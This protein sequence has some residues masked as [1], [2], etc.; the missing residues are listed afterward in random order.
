MSRIALAILL[1]A[2]AARGQGRVDVRID[3]P[4]AG[5]SSL[6]S[7]RI[8]GRAFASSDE[9]RPHLVIVIDVSGSAD[10]KS[11]AGGQT[12]LEAEI[13][14]AKAL[15]SRLEANEGTS[16]TDALE[17]SVIAFAANP[18]LVEGDARAAL[19]ALPA[20]GGGTSFG[21]ALAKAREVLDP[22]RRPGRAVVV[23]LTDGRPEDGGGLREAARLRRE[24]AR[25]HAF[26][27]GA[28]VDMETMRKIGDAVA[29]ERPADIVRRMPRLDVVLEARVARVRVRNATTGAGAE[30]R[31]RRDG[32]F[33]GVVPVD[34][35][36]GRGNRIVV[37]AVGRDGGKG[38]PRSRSRGRTGS[39]SRAML[40]TSRPWGG[41]LDPA[42]T[43]I[44]SQPTEIVSERGS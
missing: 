37:T 2:A 9:D 23:F 19:E 38:T 28:D 42:G 14:A 40:R 21:P 5:A 26:G 13:A 31:V 30:A 39:G 1:L 15:L 43:K 11:G 8:R 44:L 10:E 32:S 33:E 6:E 35:R 18:T 25:I 27:L 16:L 41:R 22:A 24:G 3:R 12:I 29:L 36:P 4:E 34:T 7:A 20:P 17:V